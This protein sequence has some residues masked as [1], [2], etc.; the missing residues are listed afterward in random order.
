MS[1]P[2]EDFWGLCLRKEG[3]Q[4]ASQIW[5]RMRPED[6][7]L[8]MEDI[9]YRYEGTEKKYI[10]HPSTYLNQKRWLDDKIP[11]DKRRL[12]QY[13]YYKEDKVELASKE[14]AEHHLDKLRKMVGKR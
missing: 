4:R 7:S 2:F 9:K 10:P 3:K 1:I 5:D 8:A 14:V 6:Q 12:P 13:H 11:K